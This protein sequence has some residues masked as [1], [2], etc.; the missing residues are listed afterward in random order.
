VYRP[1]LSGRFRANTHWYLNKVPG[2]RVGRL[3]LRYLEQGW[4]LCRF[5]DKLIWNEAVD[6]IEFAEGGDFWHAWRS[7][8][9]YIVHLHGSRYTCLHMAGVPIGRTDWYQRRLEL[10]FIARARLVIS[11]SQALL[12]VV[13][14]ENKNQF[15]QTAVIPL[16]LDPR[17]L[18]NDRATNHEPK[19]PLGVLFAARND[20][21]KGAG[22]LLKAIPL[23]RRRFPNVQFEICGMKP[24]SVTFKQEGVRFHAFLPKE[25]LLSYYR[26]AD[27]CVVPSLWESSPNSVYEAMAAG[28]AIVASDVGGIPELVVHGETG[29]LVPPSDPARLA[30]AIVDLLSDSERRRSMGVKGK[31]R[32]RHLAASDEV[33]YR[34]RD[35][36]RT[37]VE[38]FKSNIPARTI[39]TSATVGGSAGG[40]N[41]KA[42]DQLH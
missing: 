4:V 18:E 36:Y 21:V 26:Q 9:P 42:P 8:I 38:E 33:I 11:P 6:L 1:K 10:E 7:P 39:L 28:K 40:F 16:P 27:L 30:D 22:V 31:E 2:L 17:L 35:L 24:E 15:K 14:R 32:I 29:L 41:C 23:V 3:G 5:L 34:R 12:D 37:V 13:H 20:H 19:S 25:E